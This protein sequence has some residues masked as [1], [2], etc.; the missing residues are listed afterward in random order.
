MIAGAGLVQSSGRDGLSLK[1]ERETS[2]L[3]SMSSSPLK[4]VTSSEQQGGKL[5][6]ASHK[7]NNTNSG[8]GSISERK[9]IEKSKSVGTLRQHSACSASSPP[10]L[11]LLVA[12]QNSVVA[13]AL[14]VRD[15]KSES[16]STVVDIGIKRRAADISDKVTPFIPQ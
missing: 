8:G 7:A 5:D 12:D 13:S 3:H 2:G 1:K 4:I 9:M 14:K 11:L 15:I 10:S 6:I 16:T